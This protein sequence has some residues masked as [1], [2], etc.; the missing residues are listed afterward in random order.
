MAGCT[1]RCVELS[2]TTLHVKQGLLSKFVTSFSRK[3]NT[4][5]LQ[6]FHGFFFAFLKIVT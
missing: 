6:V 5:R 1:E 2:V 3:D 4:D